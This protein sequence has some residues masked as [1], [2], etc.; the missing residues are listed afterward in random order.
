MRWRASTRLRYVR[1]CPLWCPCG[2][3]LGTLPLQR[4]DHFAHQATVYDATRRRLLHGREDMLGLVAAQL[5]YKVENKE[6]KAGKA[7]WVDVSDETECYESP[8]K[9]HQS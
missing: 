6:I 9:R 4:A 3:E 1:V 2:N 5:K 7:I 8:R